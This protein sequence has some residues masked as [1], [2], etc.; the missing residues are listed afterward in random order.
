M[1]DDLKKFLEGMSEEFRKYDAAIK[2]TE[3]EYK[4]TLKIKKGL[5]NIRNY[6]TPVLRMTKYNSSELKKEE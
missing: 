3:E 1:S 5:K 6:G 4:H 2:K